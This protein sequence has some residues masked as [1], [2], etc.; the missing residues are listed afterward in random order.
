MWKESHVLQEWVCIIMPIMFSHWKC[1]SYAYWLGDG[2]RR[3]AVGPLISYTPHSRKYKWL[4]LVC[5]PTLL[6]QQ[7]HY[8]HQFSWVAQLC[9]TLCN[10]MDCSMPSFP[11]L[12]YLPEFAQTQVSWI[13]DPI[14]QFSKSFKIFQSPP[15]SKVPHTF[16]STFLG[17]AAPK[18]IH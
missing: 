16:C 11:V 2:S 10:P 4:K 7:I 1:E 12:H 8:T 9:P 14:Q 5:Y 15:N 6:R 17:N 13:G 18:N 3:A